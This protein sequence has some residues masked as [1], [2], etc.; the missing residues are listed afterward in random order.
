MSTNVSTIVRSLNPSASTVLNSSINTVDANFLKLA[1]VV[2][3]ILDDKHPFFGK[4]TTNKNRP[5]M[6]NCHGQY[7]WTILLLNFHF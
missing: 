4:T 5:H 2:D 7:H 1:V 6:T 3:I